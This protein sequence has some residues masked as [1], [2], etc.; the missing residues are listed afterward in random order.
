LLKCIGGM[1][2]PRRG[3]VLL[4]GRDLA[5]LP[6]KE[7]AHLVGYVPQSAHGTMSARV[8]D[9]VMMGRLPH[10]RFS[11]GSRD[12]QIAFEAIERLQL[13]ELAFREFDRLSGGERQRVLIARALAQQPEL[14]LLDE[15]TSSLDM[16]HQL[17]AIR[18]VRGCA[19]KNNVTVVVSL[20]DLNLAAM[21]CDRLLLL[22][23]A[24]CFALGNCDEVLTAENIREVYGV[25]TEIRQAH[26]RRHVLLM[27]SDEPR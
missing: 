17:E 3:K 16:R 20:H 24:R 26:G 15:P 27:R 11:P 23:D 10:L 2:R 14:L 22:R 8:V 12:R 9:I 19:A 4:A 21:L 25:D 13:T 1:L 5:L 6:A 18:I 7:R